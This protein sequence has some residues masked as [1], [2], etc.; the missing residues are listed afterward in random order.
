LRPCEASTLLEYWEVIKLKI[1]LK[2]PFG[3]CPKVDL[4]L[5]M[6]ILKDKEDQGHE[7]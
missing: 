7:N 5:R 2:P 6:D 1:P 4:K 3:H